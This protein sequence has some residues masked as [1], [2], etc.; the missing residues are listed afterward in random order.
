M[1][2]PLVE[3]SNAGSTDNE[4]WGVE[5]SFLGKRGHSGAPK[6]AAYS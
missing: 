2:D 1:G 5:N 6:E 4:L 3:G